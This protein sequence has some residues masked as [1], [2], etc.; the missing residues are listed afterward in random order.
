MIFEQETLK[1]IMNLFAYSEV[2]GVRDILSRLGSPRLLYLGS[3]RLPHLEVPRLP[4]LREK[5]SCLP[6]LEGSRL[7]RLRGEGQYRI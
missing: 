2:C 6:H 7:P 3:S 4:R 1:N 5:G